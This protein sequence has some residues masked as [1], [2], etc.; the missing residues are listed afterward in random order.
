M[1]RH[2]IWQMLGREVC[3]DAQLRKAIAE[4]SLPVE[5]DLDYGD[6]ETQ[7]IIQK[8]K[9]NQ[10]K[11]PQLPN[12]QQPTPPT[13]RPSQPSQLSQSQTQAQQAAENL[14]VA[15]VTGHQQRLVNLTTSLDKAETRRGEVLDRL[16]DRMAY[17]QDENLFMNDLLR[18]TQ[19]KL[20]GAQEQ[21]PEKQQ[22][23]ITAI[24][25]LVEAFDA[26]GNWELPAIMPGTS[27]GCLPM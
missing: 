3:T 26:A 14:K 12:L 16:S 22:V 23:T 8:F 15:L 7:A 5:D 25:A 9:G 13:D 4:L 27:M 19:K 20:K 1:K 11:S 18:L 21:E 17:L 10:P 6:R 2:Q 24:D